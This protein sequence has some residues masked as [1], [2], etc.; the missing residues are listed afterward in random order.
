MKK[1]IGTGTKSEKQ[2]GV[3]VELNYT[4]QDLSQGLILFGGA[5]KDRR[6][7][8]NQEVI[9]EHFRV[10]EELADVRPVR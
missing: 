10:R 8:V 9:V 6:C 7:R 2:P 3:I 4:H 5:I 1:V